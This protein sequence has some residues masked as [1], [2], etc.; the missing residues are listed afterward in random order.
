MS[1]QANDTTFSKKAKEFLEFESVPEL[2]EKLRTKKGG[3]PVSD[4]Y[5]K[6][7]NADR[8]LYF[9]DLVQ[10]GGGVLG[11]ALVGYTMALEAAGI[12]FLSLAGTSAGAIN[13]VLMAGCGKPEEEKSSIILEEMCQKEFFEFVDPGHWVLLPIQGLLG[14]NFVVKLISGI[15]LV[16][17]NFSA[18]FKKGFCSGNAFEQWVET[19]LKNR[20]IESV[21]QL[22]NRMND[23]PKGLKIRKFKE[24]ERNVHVGEISARLA[25]ISA[26]ITTQTKV[27]FPRMA[28]LYVPT[29][30][31]V[32][33]SEVTYEH[34]DL[35]PKDMVRA[36]MAIPMFFRP[37]IFTP[38]Q[39]GEATKEKWRRLAEFH[40]DIPT[41]VQ[42]VDGGIMS[43]FP[44]DLFH[45]TDHTP[46]RPT[47]GV[48][49]GLSRNKASGT[50][51]L[52]SHAGAIFNGAR[53]LRD[54]EF[55]FKNEDYKQ[56][57]QYIDTEGYDW[58]N[59][60]ISH[61]Q[62]LELFELGV[63]AAYEFLEGT[64]KGKK[65]VS[66]AAERKGFNWKEYQSLRRRILFFSSSDRLESLWSKQDAIRKLG[67]DEE[68]LLKTVGN[69][70]GQVAGR[71]AKIP[72]EVK[73]WFSGNFKSFNE[74]LTI[75]NAYSKKVGVVK[76]LWVDDDPANDFFELSVLRALDIKSVTA[77]TNVEAFSKLQDHPEILAIV[78]DSYRQGNQNE[79][80]ELC[81]QLNKEGH[82]LP[83]LLHSVSK[84]DEY[85]ENE[86]ENIDVKASFI[87]NIQK[88]Y[89]P[90]IV[91]NF[92]DARELVMAIVKE[93]AETISK[94]K[95]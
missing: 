39:N 53:N 37:K 38:P 85:L 19:V 28:E 47:F 12:R 83:I 11:V 57:V 63:Q 86:G 88:E 95:L 6:D 82:L 50:G 73:N 5:C 60:S 80:L 32:P 18:L 14:K 27:E 92:I 90:L 40:G 7:P 89:S 84:A 36:S 42:M 45:Q 24:R 61:Q 68:T 66:G 93:L 54:F 51:G 20:K 10:Q 58:L 94:K 30:P 29:K 15:S 41:K 48:R 78:T 69:K 4:I 56:L 17:F 87:K 26:D 21:S 70:I 71:M 23:L 76:I 77:L 64:Q 43:N 72:D 1:N 55:L 31:D 67:L 65:P 75:I 3:Y 74:N 59:F 62:K 13:T 81:K 34:L 8:N 44:I 22:I 52:L 49:L 25:I 35:S 9:V 16:V 79:G 2:L 91:G 46:N 33:I